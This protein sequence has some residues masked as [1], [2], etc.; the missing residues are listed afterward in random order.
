MEGSYEIALR[1][2][3]YKCGPSFVRYGIYKRD[4]PSLRSKQPQPDVYWHTH[5]R[6]FFQY[7]MYLPDK[8]VTILGRT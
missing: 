6:V 3:I 8:T 4:A 7:P 2:V 5:Y 1:L